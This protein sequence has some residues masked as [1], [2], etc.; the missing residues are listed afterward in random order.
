[1][2][3]L[4]DGAEDR[5]KVLDA[6]DIVRLI[7]EHVTLRPKGREYVGLCPFHDDHKPSMCVVPHKHMFH[8]FSCGSGGNAF[9]FM[10]K[11]HGMEFREALR[12]LADRAGIELTPW[13]GGAKPGVEGEGAGV[14]RDELARANRTA[15]DFF[16]AIYRHPEHGAAARALVKRRGMSDEMVERFGVGASPDRWDG[17]VK[18]IEGKGLDFA[19][20]AAAGLIKRREQGGGWYDAFR[21]RLMFPIL[22]QIGRPIAFGG[23]KLRDEDEPKYL[24]SPE[25]ALFHKGSTLYGI[26]AAGSA[27]RESRVCVITE[28]YTDVIAC[29]Q[30]GFAQVVATLG[31]AF[32]HGHVSQVR[33]LCDR[34][35][36][37]FDGD[38]AGEKAAERACE[39]F[40]G[41]GMDVDVAILPA[42]SDP[43]DLL[44]EGEGG[45]RFS[46]VL[47]AAEPA[48][49]FQIRRV[50]QR[51]ID[52]GVR[53][54]SLAWAQ[55]VEAQVVRFAEMGLS[56]LSPIRR[57][58]VIKRLASVAGV[59]PSIVVAAVAS[60]RSRPKDRGGEGERRAA[61]IVPKT[62]REHALACL[63]ARPELARDFQRDARDI[64]E[65]V[66]Y[67]SGPLSG[68]AASVGSFI[69]EHTP[70]SE[71]LLATLEDPTQRE[72][73]VAMIAEV[74]RSTEGDAE[75]HIRMWNDCIR[76]VRTE[77]ASAEDG[78]RGERDSLARV[79]AA[80]EA[81]RDR[82]KELGGNPLARPRVVS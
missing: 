30:H 81:F 58:T 74:D 78:E 41:E 65:A 69:L 53:A 57:Q 46:E 72:S 9:D 52:R 79:G 8:C 10:M 61:K 38:T 23:R 14:S 71:G 36:L 67:G 35:V 32:T 29:H 56:S 27:I 18:V 82:H 50:R 1:M 73:V 54:G 48:L 49:E 33:R 45:A 43:D 37:L 16:R 12:V 13:K 70:S 4:H 44:K 66:A 25:S 24:N 63:L 34:V 7:G 68:I 39:V 22:D 15:W 2:S 31:T 17:L 47:G 75:R 42:G 64:V 62:A 5:R 76:R 60:V 20:F 51:L 80:L 55:E 77:A 40:F 3:A 6:T 28:G 11:F 21:N 19:A 26:H 59:D